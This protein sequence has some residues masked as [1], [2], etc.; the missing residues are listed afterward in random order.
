MSTAEVNKQDWICKFQFFDRD[1][2]QWSE[3]L[4]PQIGFGETFVQD[5]T[6]DEASLNFKWRNSGKPN[7]QHMQ[8]A[9]IWWRLMMK[10]GY[11]LTIIN[12]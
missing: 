2:G 5:E 8:W 9:R 10:T 12:M 6:T 3:M 4:S 11:H 1:K 7:I